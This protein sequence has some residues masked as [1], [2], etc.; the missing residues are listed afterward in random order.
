MYRWI[1]LLHILGVLLFVFSHG[2]SA[3]MALR[4][5]HERNPDRI[6]VLL[7]VSG[8]S[9]GVFYVSVLMLLVGGIWAGFLG[10]WWDQGWIWAAL[11]LFVFNI[12]FMFGMATPYYRRVRNMMKIE[13]GG[14]SA[15]GPEEL[16]AV[17]RKNPAKLLTTVGMLSIGVIAYLMVIK[18]F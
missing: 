5:Q 17:L 12:A 3:A 18:P 4:L 7:Q 6:R 11:G 16:E 14:G 2:V 8:S 10:R 15:V 1:V 9:L 13:E